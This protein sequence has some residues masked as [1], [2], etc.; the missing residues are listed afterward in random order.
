[1]KGVPEPRRRSDRADAG[2]ERG[3]SVPELVFGTCDRD[4]VDAIM[5]RFCVAEFGVGISEV[6]FRAASVGVVIGA[7][8]EDGRRVVVKAH[9]PRETR[10]RLQ[11]VHDIQA[12]LF[13]SGFPCPEP[14]V[15]PVAVGRGH[16][17]AETLLDR[18]EFRDTH[19][20]ACRRLIAEA[21]ACH[22][23]IVAVATRSR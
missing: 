22:L 14:L 7:L 10:R 23:A 12:E 16:A 3:G 6:L 18:G 1:M 11:A 8:L 17:T 21:L 20:P 2:L 5:G 19:E 13:R 4:E 15:A 9:Q